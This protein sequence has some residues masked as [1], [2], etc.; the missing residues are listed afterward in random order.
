MVNFV[1]PELFM[2]GVLYIEKN[3]ALFYSNKT[4]AITRFVKARKDFE[5]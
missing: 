4:V 2:A 1:S 3:P 5:G